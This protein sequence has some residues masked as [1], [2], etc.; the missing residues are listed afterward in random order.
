VETPHPPRVTWRRTAAVYRLVKRER[1]VSPARDRVEIAPA[2]YGVT[3]RYTVEPGALRWVRSPAVYRTIVSRRLVRPAHL[4]WSQSRGAGFVHDAGGGEAVAATGDV[5]CRIR[6]PA[7]YVIVARRVLV[8]PATARSVRGPSRRILC[9]VREL[10]RPARRIVHHI[11]AV[12]SAQTVK[13]LITPARCEK[14]LTPQPPKRRRVMAPTSGTVWRRLDCARAR[15]P[16]GPASP[17]RAGAIAQPGAQP[18][19]AAVQ[20]PKPGPLPSGPASAPLPSTPPATRQPP[21]FGR[22]SQ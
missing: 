6:V 2:E 17:P 3:P 9:Y 19:G 10:R 4:A 16:Q 22:L 5:L 1:L 18:P 14:V 12:Y 21:P 11:A 15:R 20:A 7:R 13:V 8:T